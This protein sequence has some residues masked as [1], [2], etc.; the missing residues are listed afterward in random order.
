[1]L[2]VR[3][4]EISLR[5]S[6]SGPVYLRTLEGA[7]LTMQCKRTFTKRL[8]GMVFNETTLWLYLLRKHGR[9]QLIY[10][11]ELITEHV[12]GNCGGWNCL[13]AG[14]ASKACQH[15]LETRAANVWDLIQSD[16]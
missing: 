8:N 14:S 4:N 5:N 16:Q 10:S 6:S 2:Q 12:F 7:F 11:T 13:V 9:T 1:M 15:H 3:E